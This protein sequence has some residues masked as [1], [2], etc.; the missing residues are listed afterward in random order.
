MNRIILTKEKFGDELYA[1]VTTLLQILM[2]AENL[3]SV[4]NKENNSDV[5]VIEFVPTKISPVE[6][7]PYYLYPDEAGYVS[8]Y[9]AKKNLIKY[10]KEIDALRG[11]IEEAENLNMEDFLDEII[12]DSKRDGGD[13]NWSIN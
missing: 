13:L 9:I 12:K 10:E 5:V 1:N 7:F 4:Y 8:L 3:C 11:S 2:K 6:S